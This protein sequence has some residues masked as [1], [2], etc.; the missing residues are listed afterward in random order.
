MDVTTRAL[1]LALAALA[2]VARAHL[3]SHD[4]ILRVQ[5]W[6]AEGLSRDPVPPR[7]SESALN[8]RKLKVN[9][10]SLYDAM[11]KE[12][13]HGAERFARHKVRHKRRRP[14]QSGTDLPWRFHSGAGSLNVAAFDDAVPWDVIEG[15]GLGNAS[16]VSAASVLSAAVAGGGPES[17]PRDVSPPMTLRQDEEVMSEGKQPA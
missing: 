3:P 15:D 8:H 10:N 6:D 17:S 5:L 7:I 14:R 9:V 2:I 4:N 13:E 11:M 1:V 16:V 12:S